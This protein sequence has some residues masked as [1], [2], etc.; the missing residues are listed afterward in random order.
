MNNNIADFEDFIRICSFVNDSKHSAALR[1]IDLLYELANI[2]EG[3]EFTA[4]DLSVPHQTLGN[5]IYE[6]NFFNV[7]CPIDIV[8]EEPCIISWKR[9]YW[10]EAESRI[11]TKMVKRRVYK[12]NCTYSVMKQI[13]DAVC[14]HCR[15]VY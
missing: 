6:C 5:M 10:G 15:V 1:K 7:K 14:D 9:Q 8:R 2:E 11:F 13:A 3:E 12:L 4:S